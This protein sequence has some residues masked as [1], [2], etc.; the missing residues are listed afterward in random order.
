MA[1]KDSS[2][3]IERLASI[4][5]TLGSI[6]KRLFGNGQQGELAALS[7]RIEAVEKYKWKLVGAG[8]LGVI[9]LNFLTGNGLLSASNFLK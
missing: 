7:G 6:E 1:T 2:A 5:A 8:C 4:E 3:I 9:V